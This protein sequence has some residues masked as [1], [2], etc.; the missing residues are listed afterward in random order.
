MAKRS[1][2]PK[3]KARPTA[4]AF[5]S[6]VRRRRSRAGAPLARRL[7]VALAGTLV[8]GSLAYAGVRLAEDPR[9]ALERI[10]VSGAARAGDAEVAAAAA[11]QP[12]VN[13][14]LVDAGAAERRVRAL[15]WISAARIE[16]AWP[17]KLSI[18]V[19]EREPVARL[20]LRS[21]KFDRYAGSAPDLA[22]ID[23][24]G[25]VLQLG[26]SAQGDERLPVV[27]IEPPLGELAAG[28]Q[29]QSAQL[30]GALEASERLAALGVHISEISSDP[31]TGISV[32]TVSHLRVMLGDGEQL[33]RKVTLF[34]AIAQRIAHPDEV[35]YVDVRSTSAPTVQYRQ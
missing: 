29:L 12:G 11:I 15:P 8:A 35:S 26:A 31:V 16:R 13:I 22:L 9:F 2:K 25:R 18:S 30:N 5:D 4:F 32:T 20:V 33:E 3:G 14:W 27:R 17:N 1:H 7:A 34:L 28:Q 19:K 21:N 10:E 23:E 24:E 6:A